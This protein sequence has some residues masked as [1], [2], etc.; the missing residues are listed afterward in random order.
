MFH[1]FH[2]CLFHP[3]TIIKVYRKKTWPTI[4]KWLVILHFCTENSRLKVKKHC[5]GPK[6]AK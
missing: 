5:N 4:F 6:T 1:L 2:L 3:F